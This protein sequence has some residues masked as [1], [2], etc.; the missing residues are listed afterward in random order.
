MSGLFGSKKS[1]DP[2]K[3]S[4]DTLYDPFAS[5]RAKLNSF[6]T[7]KI[8]QSG[9]KYTGERV[10]GESP[11]E[12]ASY[13][14]ADEYASQPS[15]G[16]V[17]SAAQDEIKK[18]L[19]G[20]YDPSTSPYYQAVKAEA[21]KNLTQQNKFIADN[22]AGGNRYFSGARLRAQS[23]AARDVTQ[24][25]NT[26]LAGLAE[27]ERQRRLDVLPVALNAEQQDQDAAAKKAQMLQVL[28][29]LPREL[30]QSLY[31]SMYQEFLMSEY[32]Y[33]LNIAQL[34]AG[35][36]Q[37]QPIFVQNGYAPATPSPASRILSLL[38]I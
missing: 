13:K 17:L 33:P 32:E 7:D 11:I 25:L 26:T 14:F 31:D 12:Q 27:T 23:N 21:E 1:S 2:V 3:P 10:A 19:S 6:L 9:P 5:S 36:A 18:T 30:Q 16:P 22:A 8:G 20:D 38:S 15:K 34:A 28:G 37:Q 29:A 35:P 4:Y 24:N